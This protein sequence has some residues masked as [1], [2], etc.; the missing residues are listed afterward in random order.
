MAPYRGSRA[1]E[2]LALHMPT[3]SSPSSLLGRQTQAASF[4]A[5]VSLIPSFADW[6]VFTSCSC[7]LSS[8]VEQSLEFET[9]ESNLPIAQ[10]GKLRLRKR[11][12]LAQSLTSQW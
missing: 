3:H 9:G 7:V 1:W 11:L 12:A 4:S 2:H 8:S 6:C 10:I 5:S